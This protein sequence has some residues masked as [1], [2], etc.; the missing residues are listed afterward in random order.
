MTKICN[1]C[2]EDKQIDRFY[3]SKR[4]KMGVATTCKNC[5]CKK[6]RQYISENKKARSEYQKEYYKKNKKKLDAY[7]REYNTKN[8]QRKSQ[9]MS[10]YVKDRYKTDTDFK[11]VRTLRARIFALVKGK[12]KSAPTMKLLGCT[13][14]Q[15]RQHLES[16]F[17]EGMSWENHG[18]HGWHIDHIIPCASF[19]LTDPDQQRQCFH[20]TNLQPLWAEDNL[21]KSDKI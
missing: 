13:A 12:N 17:T 6:Q 20:Y 1:E 2:G 7:Q 3:K 5:C 9:Y 4:N 16:H 15:A 19:D 14:E 21:R 8:K 11:T 18:V 10:Q